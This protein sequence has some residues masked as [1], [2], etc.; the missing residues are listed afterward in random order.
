[1]TQTQLPSLF[2]IIIC[3]LVLFGGNR[4]AKQLIGMAG[5]IAVLLWML[6]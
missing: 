5:L 1:M 4:I 3:A 6:L 2:L